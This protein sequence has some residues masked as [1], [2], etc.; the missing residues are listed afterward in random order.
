[1][2]L[3]SQIR[4]RGIANVF[5]VDDSLHTDRLVRVMKP[6]LHT[7]LFAYTA[8]SLLFCMP[9]MEHGQWS[10]PAKRDVRRHVIL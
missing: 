10:L 9:E 6:T 7:E 2:I 5:H 8:V 3:R 1:M 4:H